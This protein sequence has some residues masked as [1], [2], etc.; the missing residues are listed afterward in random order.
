MQDLQSILEIFINN[1]IPVLLIAAVGFILRRKFVIDPKAISTMMFY[2]LSPAL[3]FYNLYKGNVG[4]DEFLSIYVGFAIFLS[5]LAG[6]AYFVL[7]FQGAS[8]TERAALQL[9][10]FSANLGNFGL[11][12]VNF[13][14]GADALSRAVIAYVSGTT[15]SYTLG[16][17]VASNGQASIRQ[18]LV[19][20]LKTPAIYAIAAAFVLKGLNIELP[21]AVD[22]SV[23]LLS[24]SSIPM[25]LILLGLQL[26][27]FARIS[28][29]RLLLSGTTIRLLIAP[30]IAI[31]FVAV[32]GLTGDARI[33]FIMQ[34]SMPTSV[35]SIVIATE[36]DTDCD[37][38]L[39]MI[40]LTTILSPITLSILI[41]LL[42]R[43]A[44]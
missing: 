20:V 25:M 36:F 34:A 27:Q 35:L 30:L 29:F 14:F 16:V 43:G 21:T 12:L 3:V 11:S 28:N 18:S 31:P 39:N 10:T 13:A 8:G 6:I 42:Q 19:N 23:K 9:G 5:I 40:M 1:M 32:L 44:I 41:F 38:I 22:R 7:K 15:L 26:G 33:A 2:V 37:L 17:Y 4:G 24:D